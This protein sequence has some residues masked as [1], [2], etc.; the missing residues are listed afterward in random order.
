MNDTCEVPQVNTLHRAIP[1]HMSGESDGT[2]SR[3]V[4]LGDITAE[5]A[6]EPEGRSVRVVKQL[7]RRWKMFGVIL[8]TALTTYA[9]YHVDG[10][11][12]KDAW[13]F[14]LAT[15]G[16]LVYTL[17]TLRSDLKLE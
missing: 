3:S 17:L 10:E 1:I 13:I 15:A 6:V 7:R 14:G 2:H 8:V 5:R 11:L 4:G 16:L 12:T 9:I